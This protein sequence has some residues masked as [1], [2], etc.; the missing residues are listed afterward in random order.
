MTEIDLERYRPD[1][2]G[3]TGLFLDTS[4]LFARFHP[5]AEEH[6]DVTT[7]LSEIASG[8]FPYRPLV[9]NT[10]VVDELATLLVTTG[11]HENAAM[12]LRTLLESDAVTIRRESEDVLESARDA[13]LTFDDHEI[14]FTDHYCGADMDD[15]AIDHVLAFDGDYETLGFTVLPRQ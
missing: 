6:D 13:F 1:S 11:T 2:Q 8:A 14:S 9:T 3:P 10:Y 4:G 5:D 7:F 12:A 15:R